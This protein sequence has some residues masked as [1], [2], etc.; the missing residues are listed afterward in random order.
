MTRRIPHGH[1]PVEIRQAFGRISIDTVSLTERVEFIESILPDAVGAEDQLLQADASGEAQW[2]NQSTLD[3]GGF[4]GLGDDDHTQY[5]LAD[6]TRDLT[7]IQATQTV[8]PVTDSLY[9]IGTNSKRYAVGYFDVVSIAGSIAVGSG[10]LSDLLP[11]ADSTY[12]LGSATRRW[13]EVWV[14]NGHLNIDGDNWKAYFGAN[15]DASIYY[16]GTNLVIDPKE[17]DTGYTVFLGNVDLEDTTASDEGVISKAGDRFVHNFHHPTGN[18]AVPTGRNTFVGVGAGNF[19]MGSTATSTAHGSYNVAMGS[20]AFDANTTGYFNTAIGRIALADNTTGYYN[21]AIGGGA[22]AANTTGHGNV[23]IGVEALRYNVSAIRCVAVGAGALYASTGPNNS[24]IG[25]RALY[26]N[27]GGAG[28]TAYGYQAGYSN[29]T[30]DDNFA[31][32]YGSLYFNQGGDENI[33]IGIHAGRGVSLSSYSGNLFI[34]Y[35]AGNSITTG[36]DNICIGYDADL[37]AGDVSDELNIGGIIKGIMTGGSEELSFPYDK[38]FYFGESQDAS[39]YFDGADLII[40]SEGVTAN[41]EVHFTNW[42]AVDFGA[43]NLTTSGTVTGANVT[44]G[45]DPGHTHTSSSLP[46]HDGLVGLGDDDHTQYLLASGARSLAGNLAVDALV[47]IDGRDLSVDGATLD[48]HVSSNGSDH[49][50]IDQDVTI[51]ANPHFDHLSLGTDSYVDDGIS[52][53]WTVTND[54]W[55]HGIVVHLYPTVTI[56]GTYHNRGIN[57]SVPANVAAGITN[58]GHVVG[59]MGATATSDMAAGSTLDYQTAYDSTYGHATGAVG[60]T[61][62]CYGHRLRPYIRGG[63]ITN[64]Y[65]IY[66]EAPLTGGTVTNAYS[67]WDDTGWDWVI[68]ANNAGLVLGASQQARID[69]DGTHLDLQPGSGQVKVSGGLHCAAVTVSAAGPTDNVDVSGA[70]IVYVDSSSN[71]VTI[72]GFVGGVANQVLQVVR[73]SGSNSVTLEHSEGTGNQDIMLF[74]AVDRT[75]STWGGWTLVFDGTSWNEVTARTA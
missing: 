34:G 74:G 63:T 9:T 71:N 70:N 66:F 52:G 73:T 58:S 53:A 46:D 49:S 32:G 18:T 4:G 69:Y 55:A 10:V 40:N 13:K 72:G 27:V 3:H 42:D 62:N 7:G 48:A 21:T 17:V 47:T 50:Y 75:I 68:N 28:N 30:G 12:D 25:Y 35:Q 60:T 43:S 45:A 19:T 2:I 38:P 65:N 61:T 15:Q 56:N 8:I 11:F 39:I 24:G 64:L 54:S 31:L 6:G 51:S 37:S 67:M 26:S 29:T 5:L 44:S 20:G 14:G 41:D 16:D 1:D 59:V 36:S 23:A 57:F 22:L 33:C